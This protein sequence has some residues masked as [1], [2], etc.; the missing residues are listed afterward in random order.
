M[1]EAQEAPSVTGRM[2][3]YEQPELLMKENHGEL[4]LQQPEQPFGFAAKARAVPITL[5]EIPVA[6]KDY[7]LIFMSNEQPQLLAITGLYDD[8]NLFVDE[9][10]VWDSFRYIPGY[11][12]RY[13]FGIASENDG[14][15]M[16]IVI[17]RA[18]PGFV[19]SGDVRLFDDGQMTQQTKDAI[20]FVKKYE[21]DR[22]TTDQFAAALN[23]YELIQSQSA[24]YT[25]TG[26]SE[27]VTFAQYF[28][29]DED[30][31]KAL[32]DDKIL[33]L[34]KKGLLPL[35]YA[36]LMSMGNWR[37][38]LQRRSKRF[39]LEEKDVFRPLVSQ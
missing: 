25:P 21:R 13:P 27:P 19:E 32:S 5:S 38:L 17:D 18:Y 8:I 35:I 30:R 26:A 16:A 12:R 14:E 23:E 37:I 20:D 29:I 4:C 15:R 28:G 2:F 6:M 39:N 7:P 1:S 3:L 11:L 34:Q 33:D 9:K 24:H 36:L 31:L 10:G 22:V